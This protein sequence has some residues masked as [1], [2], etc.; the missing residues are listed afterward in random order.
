[1]LSC[2]NQMLCYNT[3]RQGMTA[4]NALQDAVIHNMLAQ[5]EHGLTR[6]LQCLRPALKCWLALLHGIL[7]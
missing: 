4:G 6:T 2:S 5:N 3:F 7:P 1:M